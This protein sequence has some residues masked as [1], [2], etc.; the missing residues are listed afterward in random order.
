MKKLELHW[1]IIIGLV[2]G[3]AWAVISAYFG[4][5]EF[6]INWIKPFGDIFIR[7]LKLIAVP[8]V[9][10]S[11]ING[12]AGL[13]DVTKLGRLGAKT[14]GF[15]LLT[16]LFATTLGLTLVNTIQPGNKVSDSVKEQLIANI[17]SAE[18]EVVVDPKIAEKEK[19]AKEMKKGG[20]LRFLVELF[21]ENIFL[22]LS[23]NLLM[24]QVIVFA[25]FFGIGISLVPIEKA[26]PVRDFVSSFNDI[27]LKL[28]D[29]IMQGA[30][31]F[32][33]ALLAGVM[34]QLT[35]NDPTLLV[36]VFSGMGWFALTAV[37]GL[38]FL[39]FVFYPTIMKLT[40]R[41]ISY[42]DFF[43]KI[44]NAQLVAF[45]TSSSAATLPVT[46]D[47]VRENI[48]VS[49][50][51]TSFVLPVGATVN[52]DGTSL[53][54]AVT[55]VFLAQFFGYDLSLSAQITIVFTAALASIGTPA[56]PS[57]GLVMLIIVLESVGL[58][59][60]WIALIFPIDRP[61]DMIR[62]VVNVTGDA[63]AATVIASSEGELVLVEQE[64][65]ENFKVE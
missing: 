64:R 12:I 9:L 44:G 7:L 14:I 15:Y 30:P 10:F 57:A 56:V 47:C 29:I 28:V 37:L 54:Q 45:S 27:I 41:K 53:Y 13:S 26:K 55:A 46:M 20:P 2:L 58:P 43:R 18:G 31:F 65:I 21:P 61:L 5:S 39:I 6:T 51:V 35:K 34:A 52:M 59:A 11:I 17:Q 60:W 38:A 63:T 1:K 16:T 24:L 8:L 62:T 19:D 40:V 3:V 50:D 32:V 36:D 49:H 23:N 4:I 48:G 25:I 33:F 42:R 22:S